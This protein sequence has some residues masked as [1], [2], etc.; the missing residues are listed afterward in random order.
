MLNCGYCVMHGQF[1]GAYCPGCNF[2]WPP[3]YEP[4][5]V[6]QGWQC[7]VCQQVNAPSVLVCP[8]QHYGPAGGT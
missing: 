4:T 8:G 2:N 7:P 6:P 5:P 3:V 1:M